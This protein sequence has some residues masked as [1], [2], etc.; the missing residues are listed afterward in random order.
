MKSEK[1][2]NGI[3]VGS[4]WTRSTHLKP[5]TVCLCLKALNWTNSLAA[6]E[7]GLSSSTSRTKFAP[8]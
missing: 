4:R 7:G 8:E 5:E 1:E 2:K 6:T 3:W